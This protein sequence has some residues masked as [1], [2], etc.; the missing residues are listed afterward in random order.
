MS[1]YLLLQSNYRAQTLTPLDLCTLFICSQAKG[2]RYLVNSLCRY[3]FGGVVTGDW[4][5][6]D[7]APD[8]SL[9]ALLIPAI[10]RLQKLD[11]CNRAK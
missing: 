10:D 2:T 7:E 9:I 3:S 1:A 4:L 8:Q 6:R 11:S 5:Q